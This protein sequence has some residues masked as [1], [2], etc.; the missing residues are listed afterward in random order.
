LV[1]YVHTP[2][3]TQNLLTKPNVKQKMQ[4]KYKTQT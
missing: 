4:I 1:I 3:V 2:K